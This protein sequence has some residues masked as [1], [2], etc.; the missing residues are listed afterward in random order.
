[1]TP[2]LGAKSIEYIIGTLN[3]SCIEIGILLNRFSVC[4]LQQLKLFRKRKWEKYASSVKAP[5]IGLEPKASGDITRA[6][7]LFLCYLNRNSFSSLVMPSLSLSR[8]RDSNLYTVDKSP[9]QARHGEK[10]SSSQERLRS[11]SLF[12]GFLFKIFPCRLVGLH[13][14]LRRSRTGARA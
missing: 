14:G 4:L 9:A 5:P 11:A 3:K 1:M 2:P 10:V 13:G 8:W 6:T 7:P 12:F